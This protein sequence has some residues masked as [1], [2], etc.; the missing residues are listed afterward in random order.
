M[1]R[2]EVLKGALAGLA[3]MAREEKG[4]E[5]GDILLFSCAGG[6]GGDITDFLDPPH[7][8]Q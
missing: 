4:E 8:I 1:N 6:L 3:L 2:R 7:T 5:K